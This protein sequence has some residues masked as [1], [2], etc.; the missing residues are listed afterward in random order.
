MG[1]YYFG[2]WTANKYAVV[3]RVCNLSEQDWQDAGK[4]GARIKYGRLGYMA[5]AV[6]Q[7]LQQQ[8]D[9]GEPQT[10]KDGSYMQLGVEYK[11]DYSACN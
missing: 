4:A 7:Y 6:Q 9:K 2:A 1:T 8:A 5:L 3:N 10:E 11:V